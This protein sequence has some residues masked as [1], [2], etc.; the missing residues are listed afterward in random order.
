MG[1]SSTVVA[2]SDRIWVSTAAV[3][4]ITRRR[5]NTGQWVACTSS[6]SA[7]SRAVPVCSMAM[8]SGI[9]PAII[10]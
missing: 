3:V 4:N 1:A 10:T 9:T 2:A 6:S 8:P 7:T 5:V